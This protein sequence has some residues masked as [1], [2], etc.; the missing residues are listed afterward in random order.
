MQVSK[1]ALIEVE[2]SIT[3]EMESMPYTFF[4]LDASE[5][6]KY[7]SFR[8]KQNDLE[9]TIG[10]MRSEGK[11]IKPK[12]RQERE[13]EVQAMFVDLVKPH[14]EQSGLEALRCFAGYGEN[15]RT[16]IETPS[17]ALFENNE[18]FDVTVRVFYWFSTKDETLSCTSNL[19][20]RAKGSIIKSPQRQ[21]IY[22]LLRKVIAEKDQDGTIFP[23][24][25]FKGDFVYFA[26]SELAMPLITLVKSIMEQVGPEA[27]Q[28]L[29]I[30][31]GEY[32]RQRS[33]GEVSNTT[34]QLKVFR[35]AYQRKIETELVRAGF[36]EHKLTRVK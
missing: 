26:S 10:Q 12:E 4:T 25:S 14:L 31:Y 11:E 6:M 33:Y 24:V 15:K 3:H 2:H 27:M 19:D 22:D 13:E 7:N 35:E 18:L 30:L 36:I 23:I 32:M 21:M 5:K 28:E 17:Y 9:R 1:A 20:Y 29:N 34:I 8:G 16:F